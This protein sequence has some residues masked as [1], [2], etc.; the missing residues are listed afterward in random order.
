V[1][2]TPLPLVD[3]RIYY[4]TLDATGFSNKVELTTS[5][6]DLDRTTFGSGGAHERT[7]GLADSTA[8]L[9]VFWQA[10]DLTFPDDVAFAAAG[11][12]VQ[13]L[14]VVPTSGAVGTLAYLGKMQE[15]TYKPGGEVGKLLAA[16]VDLAGEQPIARGVILHPQGTARTTTGTGTGQQIGAVTATQRMYANFHAMS[17]SG[18]TPS[19]AVKIQ[20]SV[21]NTFGSP[22]DRITFTTATGLTSQASNVLGAITDQWWRAV[23]TITGGAQSWLFA[24]SAGIAAK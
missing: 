11:L 14:T 12:S 5:W 18:S 6:E 17:V 7:A 24:V 15:N 8:T 3:C 9:D 20:S 21:D 19:L 1:T 22:T 13:P 10:G 23:W 2:F 16:T 4:S